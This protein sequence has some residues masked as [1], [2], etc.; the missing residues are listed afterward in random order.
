LAYTGLLVVRTKE[1]ERE[2]ES[3]ASESAHG[4]IISA[5][6]NAQQKSDT[7]TMQTAPFVGQSRYEL[8]AGLAAVL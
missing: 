6:P 7:F 1:R 5:V 8:S 3:G 2:R 4:Q